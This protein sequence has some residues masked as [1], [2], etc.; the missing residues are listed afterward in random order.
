MSRLGE[1]TFVEVPNLQELNLS[2]NRFTSLEQDAFKDLKDLQRLDLSQNQ[3]EDVNGLFSHQSALIWLNL[4]ANHLLWFDYAFIP[5]SLV[6]LDIHFNN[7][8]SLGL[9]ELSYSPNQIWARRT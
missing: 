6:H 1:G 5:P 3:L 7:I 9:C 2:K 8:D 4:S